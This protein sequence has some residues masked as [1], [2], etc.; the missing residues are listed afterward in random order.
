MVFTGWEELRGLFPALKYFKAFLNTASEGLAPVG[1]LKAL[2]YFADVLSTHDLRLNEVLE[3][4]VDEAR[5]EVAKLVGGGVDEV[6]FTVQTTDGLKRVLSSLN[7]GRG[8]VVVSVDLEFPTVSSLIK[9]LCSVR[10]CVPRVVEGFG[11]YD[12]G[13]FE[14]V[15][16]DRT[17][18]VVVSSVNWVSGWRL[19]LRRLSKVVHDRGA[20]LVVDGVQHVGALKL[21]VR[22]EGVDALCVGGEKWLLNPYLGSGFMYV[23]RELIED[24]DVGV[25]GILNREPP[26]SGWSS[27]WPDPSKDP[28]SL[29]EVSKTAVRFEWGGG[30]PYPQ[31]L[32]LYEAVKLINS[33]GIESIEARVLE[34]R[35][36]L[37]KRLV[38]EGYEVLH[39]VEDRRAWSGIT[40]VK[41]G[42]PQD[43]E[44][45]LVRRLVRMGVV[46]SYRGARN[47]SGVRV[48]TH[49][50]ND[51]NDVEEFVKALNEEKVKLS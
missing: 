26:P 18:A 33:V 30:R 11:R 13:F 1:V 21:D 31:V 14:E 48:S 44:L 49:F 43:K 34:L 25:Y 42:L 45:E 4:M 47:F 6:A 38:E 3:S 24:L 8:D 5:G 22:Y 50:Y 39:H 23:R 46:V 36:Y 32:T 27:Y 19:D 12:V 9:S 51:F 20:L 16:D 2:T 7:V 41:T 40:L 37:I 17:K 28:W 10:G 29:P 15:I 35:G